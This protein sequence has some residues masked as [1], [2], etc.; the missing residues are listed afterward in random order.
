ME[1]D[2]DRIHY[3]INIDQ[4]NAKIIDIN[5]SNASNRCG[6]LRKYQHA[7]A[8]A[9][10]TI[11]AKTMTEPGRTIQIHQDNAKIGV[12]YAET[13]NAEQLAGEIHNY[14]PEQGQSLG[15]AAAE[16]QQLL[17]QLEKTYPSETVAQQEA[18]ARKAVESIE[19]NP[20]S[21]RRLLGAIR[22]AGIEV[23]M[24]LINHPAIRIIKAAFEGWQNS[25]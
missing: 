18:I 15:E 14:A 25:E 3:R 7:V 8:I 12:G 9:D 2:D 21:K 1:N 13:V 10:F 5:Q 11:R 4:S 16:I 20:A 17:D 23:F 24:E 19:K 6:L 22:E